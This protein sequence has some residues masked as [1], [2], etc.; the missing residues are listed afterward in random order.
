MNTL[1]TIEKSVIPAINQEFLLAFKSP[2]IKDVSDVDLESKISALILEC[3]LVAGQNID[4]SD[5]RAQSKLFCGDLKKFQ[6]FTIIGINEV[7]IAFRN[8][9]RKKCGEYYGLNVVTYNIW[10]EAYLKD[11]K[12]KNSLALFDK[13]K[14]KETERKISEEESEKIIHESALQKWEYFKAGKQINDFNNITYKYLDS[15]KIILFSNSRKNE[16]KKQVQ[17]K[18]INEKTYLMQRA[19]ISEKNDIKKQI[20][21]ILTGNDETLLSRCMKESLKI[22]FAELKEMGMELKDM[23]NN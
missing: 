18:M 2:K 13:S 7:A 17:E 23:F 19:D 6:H 15:K 20:D 1:Q 10:V 4:V 22:F 3:Y 16:I 9:V 12:R 5:L 11:E 14:E 21:S 8:G